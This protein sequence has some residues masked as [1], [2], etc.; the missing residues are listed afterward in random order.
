MIESSFLFLQDRMA[1]RHPEDRAADGMS[2]DGDPHLDT[3]LDIAD[4][5]VLVLSRDGT[6]RDVQ[7]GVVT[8]S[9]GCL[10]R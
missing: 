4:D 10:D 9:A 6:I 3:A 8:R 7:C 1:K 5:V 2:P